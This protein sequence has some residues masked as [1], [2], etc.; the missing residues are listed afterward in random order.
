[1][2]AEDP[3]QFWL[4]VMGNSDDNNEEAFEGF[5][6]RELGKGEESDTNLN[7]V[8]QQDASQQFNNH[9][10]SE[11]G[12]EEDADLPGAAGPNQA[13]WQKRMSKKKRNKLTTHWSA[14]T[15]EINH[16]KFDKLREEGKLE[17][18]V[19]H[20]LP[21]DSTPFDFFSLLLPESFWSDVAE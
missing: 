14:Q 5:T 9:N 18:G 6:L 19:S 21:A 15:K 2:A 12:G 16:L 4:N 20:N 7:L 3:W 1:M 17:V 13:K 8:V 10:E 11:S